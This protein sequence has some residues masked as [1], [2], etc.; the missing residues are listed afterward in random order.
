MGPLHGDPYCYCE[1]QCKGLKPSKTYEMTEEEKAKLDKILS[2]IFD[3][4]K[5]DNRN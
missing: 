1:M 3:W 2:E 4:K 5:N